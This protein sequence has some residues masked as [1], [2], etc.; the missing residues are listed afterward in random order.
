[1]RHADAAAARFLRLSQPSTRA[2]K[3]NVAGL[4]RAEL[5]RHGTT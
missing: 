2:V 5:F 3:N 4:A 1:M